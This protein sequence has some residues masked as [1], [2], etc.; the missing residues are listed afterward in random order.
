MMHYIQV[1]KKWKT[2]LVL[3]F[4]R[5]SSRW[6]VGGGGAGWF[7]VGGVGFLGGAGEVWGMGRGEGGG[8]RVELLSG[9]ELLLILELAM[10]VICP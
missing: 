8:G 1:V 2:L 7:L 5:R 10:P 3:S 6:G 9:L 4:L